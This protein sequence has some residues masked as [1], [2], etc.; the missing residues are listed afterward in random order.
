MPQRKFGPHPQRREPHHR[1]I[2]ER[3]VPAQYSPNRLEEYIGRYS[4]K[5]LYLLLALRV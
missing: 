3:I 1:C 4:Q 5:S 2:V